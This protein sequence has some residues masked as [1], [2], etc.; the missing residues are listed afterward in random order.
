M[1][2]A[3]H[4][5]LPLCSY[6]VT[7]GV[8]DCMLAFFRAVCGPVEDRLLADLLVSSLNLLIAVSAYLHVG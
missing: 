5:I 8:F 3:L 2:S 7:V 4:F 1:A 6:I